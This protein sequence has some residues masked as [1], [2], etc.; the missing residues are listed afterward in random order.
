MFARAKCV[1]LWSENCKLQFRKFYNDKADGTILPS[2]Q[3]NTLL[4]LI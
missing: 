2:E 4:L 3:L 1:N